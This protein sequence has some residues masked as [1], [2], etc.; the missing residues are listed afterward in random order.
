MITIELP[1]ATRTQAIAS[2][3]RYF[4]ESISESVGEL[5]AG[6]LLDFFVEEIGPTIYNRAILDAQDRLQLRVGDLSGELYADELQYWQR[7][8]AKKKRQ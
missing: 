1:K 6:L 5:A 7:Q 3:R 8:A 2:I 4:E